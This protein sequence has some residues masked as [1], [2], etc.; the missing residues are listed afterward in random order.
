MMFSAYARPIRRVL[1]LFAFI[2]F[3]ANVS[4][5]A[6]A[7]TC[8]LTYTAPTGGGFGAPPINAQGRIVCSSTVTSPAAV[9][10]AYLVKDGVTVTS[11]SGSVAGKT[12]VT[13]PLTASC[14]PGNWHVTVTGT[15]PGATLDPYV[16]SSPNVAIDCGTSGPGPYSDSPTMTMGY[17]GNGSDH[18]FGF[19]TGAG[20]MSPATT[21][22]GKT[23][24]D[25]MDH[26]VCDPFTGCYPGFASIT[27]SGFTSDPGIGWLI[28][29]TATGTTKMGNTA[30]YSYNSSLGT[31]TWVWYG[32]SFGF[33]GGGT[34]TVTIVHQ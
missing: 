28:S 11:A 10:N 20:S 18:Y 3:A 30:G 32:E 23:Y 31:A 21:V 26:Y 7:V 9:V 24:R 4:T 17:L 22:N 33:G 6:E 14:S 8:V 5:P 12:S 27:L 25:F 2:V 15:V 13:L 19:Q 16:I 34:T 1:F 29:A